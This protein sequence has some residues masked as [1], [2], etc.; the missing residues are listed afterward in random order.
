[1]GGAG[2]RDWDTEKE[3]PK[4]PKI[5]CLGGGYY[6]VIYSIVIKRAARFH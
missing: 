4:M 2:E 1:L 6:D 5:W 3:L